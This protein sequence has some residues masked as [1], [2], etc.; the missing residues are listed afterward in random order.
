MVGHWVSRGLSKEEVVFIARAWNERN[1]PPLP[2]R[3]VL[4][5]VDS[6]WKMHRSQDS[7]REDKDTDITREIAGFSLDNQSCSDRRLPVG[8]I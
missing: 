1:N 4:T 7:E 3:E 8:P 2:D 5:P 6:I